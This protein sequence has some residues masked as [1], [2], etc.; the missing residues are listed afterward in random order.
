MNNNGDSGDSDN[1]WFSVCG[2]DE[3]LREV[4]NSRQKYL[5]DNN[6]LNKVGDKE[7]NYVLIKIVDTFNPDSARTP[8]V[9]DYWF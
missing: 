4:D 1:D 2:I 7:D 3:E 9:P 6:G 5:V 8:T